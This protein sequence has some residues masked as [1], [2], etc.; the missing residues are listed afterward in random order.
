MEIIKTH[1]FEVINYD[2][3]SLKKLCAQLY[4]TVLKAPPINER[5]PVSL[6]VQYGLNAI[7]SR[8][9]R[10]TKPSWH[11]RF[12]DATTSLERA[13]EAICTAGLCKP[14]QIVAATVVKY[15][16]QD[17]TN[18]LIVNVAELAPPVYEDKPRMEFKILEY[19]LDQCLAKTKAPNFFEYKN[20]LAKLKNKNTESEEIPAAL[21]AVI[22]K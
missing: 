12:P 5:V 2:F 3:V 18:R 19:Y 7:A 1:T 14:Q 13:N 22:N 9:G 17:K 8:V 20:L 6:T 16:V 11:L 15:P 4:A 10:F 21:L